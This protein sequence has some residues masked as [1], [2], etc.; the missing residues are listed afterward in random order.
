MKAVS[1][2]HMRSIEAA[3]IQQGLADSRA[4]MTIAGEALA[5]EAAAFQFDRMNPR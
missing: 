5:R 1:G 3:A 4:M 2:T